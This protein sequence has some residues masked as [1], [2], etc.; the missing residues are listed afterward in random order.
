MERILGT[1]CVHRRLVLCNSPSVFNISPAATPQP[2]VAC[3]D[4]LPDVATATAQQEPMATLI[5]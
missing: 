1:V 3:C 5:Q 4:F 2:V